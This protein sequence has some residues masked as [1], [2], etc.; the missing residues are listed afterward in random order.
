MV[1]ALH[2]CINDYHVNV[3]DVFGERK[4]FETVLIVLVEGNEQNGKFVLIFEHAGEWAKEIP[5]V[6]LK[7]GDNTPLSMIS[8]GK[9]IDGKVVE[10]RVYTAAGTNPAVAAA[11]RYIISFLHMKK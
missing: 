3:H 1:K 10:E 4:I 11:H 7:V 9:V 6:P 2:E 8:V 5:E